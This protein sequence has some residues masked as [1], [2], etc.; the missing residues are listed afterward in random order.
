MHRSPE[1]RA[2]TL[3]EL[4]VAMAV[5]TLIMLV[6]VSITN[7]TSVI[8]R[9]TTSEVEQF[10]AARNAFE[11]MTRRISQATLNTCWDYSYLNFDVT[12][13]QTT[14]ASPVKFA[15]HYRQHANPRFNSISS[16]ADQGHLLSK[17]RSVSLAV[18]AI[19]PAWITY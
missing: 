17:R 7:S 5:L 19:S 2:F 4:L 13:P 6:L 15:F 12:K 3:V 10:R 18:T 9:S 1:S 14:Y 11:S 16:P 8:W